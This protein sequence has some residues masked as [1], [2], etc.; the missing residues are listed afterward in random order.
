MRTGSYYLPFYTIFAWFVVSREGCA[1]SRFS[2]NAEVEP[3][4]LVKDCIGG[5]PVTERDQLRMVELMEM[6]SSSLEFDREQ[7]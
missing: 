1:R 3:T 4:C 7:R 6:V 5:V 2:S